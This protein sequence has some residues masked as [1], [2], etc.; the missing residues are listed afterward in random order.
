MGSNAR[1]GS[2]PALGT[3]KSSR[4]AKN[5]EDFVCSRPFAER[6]RDG[7]R[8][9]EKLSLSKFLLARRKFRPA[10]QKPA[11]ARGKPRT[12]RPAHSAYRPDAPESRRLGSPTGPDR[13]KWP[14]ERGAADAYGAAIRPEFAHL[15]SFCAKNTAQKHP[16][17]ANNVVSL[18][19]V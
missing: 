13:R 6:C 3:T 7:L 10:Q 4:F 2:S 17:C 18:H 9:G 15:R 11:D 14:S 8:N 5:R 19:R 12:N 16:L 1:A